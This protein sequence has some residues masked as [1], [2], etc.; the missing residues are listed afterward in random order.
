MIFDP[1]G[2]LLCFKVRCNRP[3][4]GYNRLLR[5]EDFSDLS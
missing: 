2:L 1:F 3:G 4:S 5:F